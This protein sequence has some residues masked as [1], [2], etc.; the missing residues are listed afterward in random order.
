[1]RVTMSHAGQWLNSTRRVLAHVRVN[2]DNGQYNECRDTER[3]EALRCGGMTHYNIIHIQIITQHYFYNILH[4]RLNNIHNH[5]NIILYN[6]TGSG[7]D[8]LACPLV[9]KEGMPMTTHEII[10]LLILVFAALSYID[11]HNK[12]K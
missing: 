5:V 7:C 6:R 10:D 4:F 3:R 9:H 2:L 1:M 12:K 11:I 8:F